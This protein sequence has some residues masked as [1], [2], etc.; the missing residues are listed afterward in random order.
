MYFGNRYAR[1]SEIQQRDISCLQEMMRDA[2]GHPLDF[3]LETVGGETDATEAIISMFRQMVPSI[4]M[5]VAN[6]AKSSGTMLALSS[7][8]IVMGPTSE[9]GPIEP[10][11]GQF[12][13]STLL[14]DTVREKE[15][16]LHT[17]AIHVLRQAELLATKLLSDGMMTGRSAAEIEMTV[18][19][20]VTRDTYPVH[21][22]VI[23][24][25][26]AS[27]LGL[28]VERVEVGDPLWDRI[29]LLY[30]MYDHDARRN[31]YAKVFEGRKC[32]LAIAAPTTG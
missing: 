16:A 7:T 17:M 2:G 24:R 25:D 14:T 4:R 32:S 23:D 21:G 8:S 19:A 18:K 29:W 26:E 20:L 15:F 9:L 5:F 1:G 3:L 22:S 6:S 13:V 10:A 12:P 30:C 28:N 11:I 31:G 27:K